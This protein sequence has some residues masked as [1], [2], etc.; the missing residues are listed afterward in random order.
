MH[1]S[2]ALLY[3]T[4]FFFQLFTALTALSMTALSE[5]AE[6]V[7]I[8]LIESDID[9]KFIRRQVRS[10]LSHLSETK[11]Y[12]RTKLRRLRSLCLA[13]ETATNILRT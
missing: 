3:H 2:N 7:D 10:H 5:S 1:L 13:T 4:Y 6:T 11:Y 12:D 9:R 8:S